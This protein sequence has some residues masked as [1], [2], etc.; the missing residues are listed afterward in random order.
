VI[1]MPLVNPFNRSTSIPNSVTF[2][3]TPLGKMKAEDYNGDAETQ[4][5]VAIEENGP[6]NLSEL[7][8]HTGLG[9]NRVAGVV[10]KALKTGKIHKLAGEE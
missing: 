1:E 9:R 3:L 4:V 2:T 10:R 6:S 7:C 5:L 8:A